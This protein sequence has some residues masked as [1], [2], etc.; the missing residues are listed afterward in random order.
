LSRNIHPISLHGFLEHLASNSKNIRESL[1]CIAKYISNK[2]IDPKK[3]N[4]VENLKNV[5]ETIWSL[6]YS[7][8]QSSWDLL[9]TDNNSATL[10]QKVTSK[11]TPKVKSVIDSN[12]GNKYKSVPASIEKL[13]PS[14][15]AKL[16]KK[17]NQISKFFKNLK[18]VLVD[19]TGGKSYM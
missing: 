6:I 1:N 19:K 7:V 2:Q 5:S 18:Q 4:N 16:P 11:F 3:S 10:R 8:Y 17:V 15:L 12:N 14:I 13:S 9:Y